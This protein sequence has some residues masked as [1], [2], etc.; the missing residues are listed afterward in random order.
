MV[1]C[2]VA[3]HLNYP[4]WKNAPKCLT[5]G[6]MW[7]LTSPSKGVIHL[8]RQWEWRQL[9]GWSDIMLTWCSSIKPEGHTTIKTR[10]YENYN[11]QE[12]WASA[13]LTSKV[14]VTCWWF[15]TKLAILL[16]LCKIQKQD[17][18]FIH[19]LFLLLLPHLCRSN[20]DEEE[21]AEMAQRWTE[22]R[23]RLGL[24]LS[25]PEG[26]CTKHGDHKLRVSV[27]VNSNDI[28]LSDHFKTCIL[29]FCDK[30]SVKTKVFIYLLHH[31]SKSCL[32]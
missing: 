8:M 9:C 7:Q 20:E 30:S 21:K 17:R 12:P 6:Q 15:E 26:R 14:V 19:L 23:P 16:F 31:I 32:C 2:S 18:M 5:S 11:K 4:T 29:C 10:G 22:A 1:L 3:L 13:V 25:R 27:N 28:S 24:S